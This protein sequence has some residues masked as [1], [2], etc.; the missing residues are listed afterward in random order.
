MLR[1]GVETLQIK[2]RSN[3]AKETTLNLEKVDDLCIKKCANKDA[4]IDMQ[5]NKQRHN[6]AWWRLSGNGL[7]SWALPME[8]PD[9]WWGTLMPIM[10]YATMLCDGSPEL[11]IQRACYHRFLM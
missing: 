8:K 10:K 2:F 6:A 5:M 1:L 9:Q 7:T 11:G 4:Q 3:K